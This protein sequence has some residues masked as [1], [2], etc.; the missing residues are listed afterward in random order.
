MRHAL[1]LLTALA[2]TACAAEST[3]PEP[4]WRAD[5]ATALQEAGTAKQP[6]VLRFT[7]VWCPPCQQMAEN[8]WPD[9]NVQKALQPYA[10]IKVDADDPANEAL[11]VRFGVQPIPTT[12]ILAADGSERVRHVGYLPPE[13]MVELLNAP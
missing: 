1:I 3:A 11:F 12:V 4:G 13:R 7:A 5:A 8:T 2:L 10:R 9:A 6:I